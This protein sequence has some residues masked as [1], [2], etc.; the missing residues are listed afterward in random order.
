MH[1][2]PLSPDD[3]AERRRRWWRRGHRPEV[4]G[5]AVVAGEVR[6]AGH[7]HQ[8]QPSAPQ[9]LAGALIV[10]AAAIYLLLHAPPGQNIVY[11]HVYPREKRPRLQ[12]LHMIL[13]HNKIPRGKNKPVSPL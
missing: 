8:A 7:R 4:G 10:T 11:M 12:I 5:A 1:G 2:R 9:I 13:H 6:R 3:A